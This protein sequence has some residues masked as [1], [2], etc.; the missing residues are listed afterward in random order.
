MDQV[1]EASPQISRPILVAVDFS[2]P[3]KAALLWAA[4]AAV[5]FGARLHVLHVVHD[6]ASAPGSYFA[7]QSDDSFFNLEDAGQEMLAAFLE[8]T[9]QEHP[10]FLSLEA[11]GA[12]V[13]PGLPTTRIL[14]MAEKLQ[15]RLIVV[16][17]QGLTG[18]PRFMLGSTAQ[19]V[20]QLA[21]IPVT[22]VKE[23]EAEGPS[24]ESPRSDSTRS[25]STR[26]DSAEESRT[27]EASEGMT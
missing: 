11:P 27:A 16:G 3:A 26:P 23:P 14:E 24:P 10:D 6:P 17:S 22:I 2:G 1:L 7:A 8:E 25:D 21:S 13:V 20:A 12:T 15:A 4:R 5:V 9:R 19:R 18:L